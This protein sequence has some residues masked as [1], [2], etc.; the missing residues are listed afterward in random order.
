MAFKIED[1]FHPKEHITKHLT[2]AIYDRIRER[3]RVNS[4]EEQDLLLWWEYKA[5]TLG[6]DFYQDGADIYQGLKIS[7][8]GLSREEDVE[9]MKGVLEEELGKDIGQRIF[10]RVYGS[11][12]DKDN[13]GQ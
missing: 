13:G 11:K 6:V 4:W 3:T 9:V 8:D 10:K 12:E 7:K 2:G 5:K 1:D